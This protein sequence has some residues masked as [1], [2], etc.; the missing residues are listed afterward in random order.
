MR[1]DGIERETGSRVF[2]N[3]ISK[4]VPGLGTSP[5][6]LLIGMVLQ[7]AKQKSPSSADDFLRGRR[8]ASPTS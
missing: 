4:V 8:K 2:Y 5:L 6:I 3:S 1:Y 7:K